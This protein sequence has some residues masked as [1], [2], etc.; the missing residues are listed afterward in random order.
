MV[1]P[2]VIDLFF[3]NNSE[4]H[5]THKFVPIRA[6]TLSMRQSQLE[7]TLEPQDIFDHRSHRE[8]GG[9]HAPAFVR[10]EISGDE[11]NAF[12]EVRI[13]GLERTSEGGRDIALIIVHNYRIVG[14]VKIDEPFK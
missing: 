2:L 3:W 4:E 6:K 1:D 13:D 7:G 8:M 11:E 14:E 5:G 12:S 9:P 10:S